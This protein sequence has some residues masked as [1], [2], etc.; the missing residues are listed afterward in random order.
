MGSSKNKTYA[1]ALK[2]E[3]DL[4]HH[5][6]EKHGGAGPPFPPRK[7][8]VSLS[9]SDTWS[10]NTPHSGTAPR[11]ARQ[12]A[13]SSAAAEDA[14]V[15]SVLIWRPNAGSPATAGG[16]DDHRDETDEHGDSAAAVEVV[17]G[18]PN[19]LHPTTRVGVVQ[20]AVVP[21]NVTMEPSGP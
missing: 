3:V 12:S 17:G 4:K 7:W 21:L 14:A 16:G 9:K 20:V 18:C 5:Q 10:Q 13:P 2:H 15:D 8:K 11:S 19:M 6:N 1:A